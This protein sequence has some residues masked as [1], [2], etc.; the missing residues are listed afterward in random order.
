MEVANQGVRSEILEMICRWRKVE[1]AHGS[2]L[3]LGMGEHYME[4]SQAL[5]TFLK[6]S[7]P[8]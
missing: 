8:L 3:N 1:R 7:W 4:V 6:Y 5:E 2:V